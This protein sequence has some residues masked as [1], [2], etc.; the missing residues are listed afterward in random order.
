[1]ANIVRDDVLPLKVGATKAISSFPLFSEF[2]A[3]WKRTLAIEYHVCIWQ[4]LS[5]VSYGGTCEI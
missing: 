3:L 2:L 1:M 5:Q 4:V